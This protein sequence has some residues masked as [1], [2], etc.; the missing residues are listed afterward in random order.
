MKYLKYILLTS[1]S[2][3]YRNL[4]IRQLLHLLTIQP[5]LCS[6]SCPKMKR[7]KYSKQA[8]WC[9]KWKIKIVVDSF[10]ISCIFNFFFFLFHFRWRSSVIS[11]R[12]IWTVDGKVR[13]WKWRYVQYTIR[14]NWNFIMHWSVKL[15]I[16]NVH[17]RLIYLKYSIVINE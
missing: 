16:N 13:C 11:R 7:M 8:S 3:I 17:R 10:N 14:H 2:L 4:K 1:K 12:I 5:F 9:E 6:S 15:V